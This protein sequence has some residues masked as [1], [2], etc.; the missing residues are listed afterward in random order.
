ML[1]NHPDV[2]R[3]ICSFFSSCNIFL[4]CPLF[5]AHTLPL[6]LTLEQKK[7][8]KRKIEREEREKRE[9]SKKKCK[10]RLFILPFSDRG[11]GGGDH[12]QGKIVHPQRIVMMVGRRK[13]DEKLLITNF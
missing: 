7:K 8:I 12:E 2:T 11:K 3:G 10:E 13:L 9:R 4:F 1:L 6:A 5:F